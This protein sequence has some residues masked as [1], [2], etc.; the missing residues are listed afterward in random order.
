MAERQAPEPADL[1]SALQSALQT[2]IDAARGVLDV[3]E[4]LVHDP[5]TTAKATEVA[6]SVVAGLSSL[7]SRGLRDDADTDDGLER[8]DVE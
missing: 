6:E 3:A 7:R 5:S 2:M 8:I 4:R 1:V